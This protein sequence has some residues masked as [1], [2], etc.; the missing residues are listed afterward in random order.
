MSACGSASANRACLRARRLG[1]RSG[2]RNLET[3]LRTLGFGRFPPV[4]P[5]ALHG[6]SGQ[7]ATVSGV[8]HDL[9]RQRPLSATRLDDRRTGSGARALPAPRP[10][11]PAVAAK[12]AGRPFGVQIWLL[13]AST[14]SGVTA[15]T[16]HLGAIHDAFADRRPLIHRATTGRKPSGRLCAVGR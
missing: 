1:R 6:K 5:E 8:R 9:R 11:A 14:V 7:S 10:P 3:I 16:P 12:A 15:I 13:A 4:S 2:W